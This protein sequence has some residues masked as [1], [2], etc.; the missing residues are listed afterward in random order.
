MGLIYTS[1]W[2]GGVRVETEID[3]ESAQDTVIYPRGG[4]GI[5]GKV[6]VTRK[7]ALTGLEAHLVAQQ[8]ATT[9]APSR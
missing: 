8:P 1:T 2:P 4:P 3:G 5:G 9:Q 6:E 7:R